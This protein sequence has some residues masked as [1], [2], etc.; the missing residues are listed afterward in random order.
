MI[1]DRKQKELCHPP[2]LLLTTALGGGPVVPILQMRMLRL[3]E[4]SNLPRRPQI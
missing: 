3:R 2:H 4:V 1:K